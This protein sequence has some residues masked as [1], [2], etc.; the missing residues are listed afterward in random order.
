MNN[1]TVNGNQVIVNGYLRTVV[2]TWNG[3]GYS[4]KSGLYGGV[5]YVKVDNVNEY[6]DR[7][8]SAKLEAI[9]KQSK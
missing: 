4:F 5:E 1:V 7:D 3:T 6:A 8:L 2:A 9:Y